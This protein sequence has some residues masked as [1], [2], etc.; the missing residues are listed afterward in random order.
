MNNACALFAKLREF[1]VSIKLGFTIEFEIDRV[2][3][4][5]S[6]FSILCDK[7]VLVYNVFIII[8]ILILLSVN[9]LSRSSAFYMQ[10]CFPV[11]NIVFHWFFI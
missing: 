10:Y 11:T 2:Q 9:T 5:S 4:S 8:I 1:K 7:N 3:T 6:V